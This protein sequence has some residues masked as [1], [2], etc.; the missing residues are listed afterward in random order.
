MLFFS[1]KSPKKNREFL[2]TFKLQSAEFLSFW[3]I[4][5]WKSR[6]SSWNF[7]YITASQCRTPFNFT[8]FFMIFYLPEKIMKKIVKLWLEV[9]YTMQNSIHFDEIFC[10]AE[11]GLC[12]FFTWFTHLCVSQCVCLCQSVCVFWC[13][14]L[15]L[16]FDISCS[17]LR[18][19]AVLLREA[20]PAY[21]V[22]DAVV[23]A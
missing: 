14:L 5:S 2:F 18:R 10:V 9:S 22:R 12:F 3:R 6:K 11:W 23:V 16:R 8:N 21:S 19:T 7:V 1:S 17:G 20:K 4:I 15:L 13:R